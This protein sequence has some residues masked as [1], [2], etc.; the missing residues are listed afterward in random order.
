MGNSFDNGKMIL[1]PIGIVVNEYD[2]KYDAPSQG[3]L[4]IYDSTAKIVL[5]K[6]NNFEQALK[7]LDGFERIWL[8]FGFDRVHG[9]KEMVQPPRNPDPKG[10]KIGLF[11]T[12]SPHRPNPIGISCV[13]L[14]SINGLEI[15]I[16]EYD[17]LNG[18]PI[19]DIKPY[20]PYS[21]SF[22]EAKAGWTEDIEPIKEYTIEL[23]LD[24][25]SKN[26]YNESL[27]LQN[28]IANLPIQLNKPKSY[29]RIKIQDNNHQYLY[30]NYRIIFTI[31][32]Q[33]IYVK[34]I[35]KQN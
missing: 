11:A 18:T 3:T 30:K 1:E 20:L 21:D 6:G 31:K 9:W 27:T 14:L 16:S 24:I 4:G 19:Y 29:S 32:D 23:K 28:S 7:F 12:R 5:N 17:L 34:Q 10:H 35:L 22:P 2:N 13:K 25:Q 26:I 8:I 33:T 15:N